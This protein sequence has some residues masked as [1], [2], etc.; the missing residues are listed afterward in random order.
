MPAAPKLPPM[1]TTAEVWTSP[2]LQLPM[3]T[4]MTGSFGQ[5]TQVCQRVIPGEPHPSAFQ[6]PPGY[7]VIMPTP[8]KP[9][10][11]PKAPALPKPPAPPALPKLPKL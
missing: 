11:L 1:P 5:T 6:I 3:A 4:K 9:P 7:K 10:A 2:K 8:P